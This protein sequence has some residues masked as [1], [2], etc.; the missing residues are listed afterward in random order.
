[1]LRVQINIKIVNYKAQPAD[2]DQWNAS[3]SIELI[4]AVFIIVKYSAFPTLKTL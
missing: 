4:T 1:M 3:L 2:P